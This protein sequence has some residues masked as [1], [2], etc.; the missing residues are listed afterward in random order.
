MNFIAVSTILGFVLCYIIV[1]SGF[2]LAQETPKRGGWLKVATDAAPV[3]LDPQL[4]AAWSTL[5][6]V[7]TC[8]DTLVRYNAKMDLEP[9]L[10]TSWEQPD[11][12]SYIFHLRKGVKFH[13]GGDFTAE[14]VKFN[15][16]R[17]LDP[18]TKAP[19]ASYF[20]SIAKIETPDAYTVKITM[21]AP[22][23]Q[24][25]S[26][27]GTP[28]YLPI[29][30]KAALKKYGTLQQN[31]VG[32]G[33]FKMKQYEPGVKAVYER[34]DNYWEKGLP[35]I[36]GYDFII[37]KDETSRVA[38]L[39]NGAVD[40][41]WVKPAEL[42]NLLSKEKNLRIETGPP[43]RQLCF[44]FD[45][46]RFP[47]NN[48]KVRQAMASALNRQEIIDTVLMGQGT[49][50]AAVPPAGAP[51]GLSADEC[52]RLPFYK[53]DMELSRKLLKEAGYPEGFEFLCSTSPH[54][55]DYVPSAEIIQSQLAKVGIKMKIQQLEW[56]QIMKDWE[57]RNFTSI[58]WAEI[59]YPDPEGYCYSYF[60][61]KGSDN[62]YKVKDE[63]LDRLFDAQHT[64]VNLQKRISLWRELQEYMAEYI[65]QIWLYAGPA[66][67]EVVNKKVKNYKFLSNNSRIYLRQA[68]TD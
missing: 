30:S 20:K 14:D 44:L 3:G 58:I 42:A 55:P 25:M 32:T 63:K 29:L 12:L 60:H 31:V 59:W 68:W 50:S 51:Y 46:G 6:F 64:E 13:D 15:L 56:G 22:N 16:E 5:T 17:L 61:S 62:V 11:Q 48:I 43:V 19:Q 7:E 26:V 10:A 52:A 39:R 38:A 47:G 9:S 41:G 67:F 24:F 53:Q 45:H 37:I 18:Q 66:R 33:P 34:F 49:F 54:S 35:Y 27:I 8:Y 21:S 23:P 1:S 57:N 28:W 4:S 65:P 36:D 2:V 40:I